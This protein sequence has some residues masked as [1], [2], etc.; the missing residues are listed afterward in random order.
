MLML[1]PEIKNKNKQTNK[2]T[3]GTGPHSLGEIGFF[4]PENSLPQGDWVSVG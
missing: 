2:K 4:S 1:F 3:Q